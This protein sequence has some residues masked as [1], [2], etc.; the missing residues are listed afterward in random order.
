MPRVDG[1]KGLLSNPHRPRGVVCT[2]RNCHK[3]QNKMTISVIIWINSLWESA[4]DQIL[5]R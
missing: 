5:T 3:S 2:V 1:S 4:W